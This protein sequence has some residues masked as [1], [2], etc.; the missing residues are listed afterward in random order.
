MKRKKKNKN[1]REKKLIIRRKMNEQ[2][3]KWECEINRKKRM[4]E[5]PG[6]KMGG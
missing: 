5:R 3:K 1:R 2:G 6:L 4:N